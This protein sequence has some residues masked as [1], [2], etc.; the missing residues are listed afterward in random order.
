MALW[1]KSEVSNISNIK[2]NYKKCY[3]C[4]SVFWNFKAPVSSPANLAA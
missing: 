3:L 1:D 4:M 2:E